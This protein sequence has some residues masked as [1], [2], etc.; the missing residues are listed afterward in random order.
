MAESVL[1]FRQ[2]S[3]LFAR[4]V[5]RSGLQNKAFSQHARCK[6]QGFCT[7]DCDFHLR[8]KTQH[9]TDQYLT[10]SEGKNADAKPSRSR[11]LQHFARGHAQPSVQNPTAFRFPP[12]RGR[13]R[14]G[15]SGPIL[16]SPSTS[17]RTNAVPRRVAQSLPVTKHEPS[18]HH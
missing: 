16:H 14:E 17:P 4:T 15:R 13:V 10:A 3:L 12:L 8:S 2:N 5:H 18:R 7:G 1:R 9:D 6:I 11:G